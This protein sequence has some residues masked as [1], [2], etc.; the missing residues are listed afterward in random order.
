VKTTDQLNP[1]HAAQVLT[2]LK[3]ASIKTGLLINFNVPLL[4][5]GIRRLS[6]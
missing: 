5:S 4:K 6:I 1:V 2:N 3:L